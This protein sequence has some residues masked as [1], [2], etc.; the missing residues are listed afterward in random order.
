MIDQL[1]AS[2]ETHRFI[3]IAAVAAGVAALAGTVFL[4]SSRDTLGA[5]DDYWEPIRQRV[6]PV[7]HRPLS[8]VGGYALAYAT[9]SQYTATVPLDEEALERELEEMGFYRNPVAALKRA[10]DRRLSE[11]S[12]V[13]RQADEPLAFGWMPPGFLATWQLHVTVFESPSG[14][15]DLYAHHELNPWRHPLKHL[16]GVHLSPREGVDLL[17]GML[18]IHSVPHRVRIQTNPASGSGSDQEESG[19]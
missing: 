14:G 8:A 7:L 10:G 17:Q 6:W 1:A 9:S 19:P 16:R 3:I 5:D 13:Y 18:R 4:A 12:W 2:L 11:G 15:L